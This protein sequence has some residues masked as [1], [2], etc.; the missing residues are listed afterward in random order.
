MHIH[1]KM[2]LLQ[3]SV[4][5]IWGL[6]IDSWIY[7]QCWGQLAIDCLPERAQAVIHPGWTT[8]EQQYFGMDLEG[9]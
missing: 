3:G 7:F 4:L 6:S 8:D 1:S 9:Q 5:F 2:L